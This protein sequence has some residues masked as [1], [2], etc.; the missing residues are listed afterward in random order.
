VKRHTFH[1]E[2]E[3]EYADA[4]NYYFQINPDL[5]GRFYD[6]IERLILDIR[7]QPQRFRIFDA[8]AR[9]HFS[10][11]FPYAILLSSSPTVSG[12]SR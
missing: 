3:K 2:A 6:E 9:R 11:V 7:T 12:L 5:A 1:P 8:P 10:T 4:A